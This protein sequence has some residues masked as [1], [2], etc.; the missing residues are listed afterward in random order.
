MPV[1][2]FQCRAAWFPHWQTAVKGT[3]PQRAQIYRCRGVAG[4]VQGGWLNCLQLCSL[5]FSLVFCWGNR[6]SFASAWLFLWHPSQVTNGTRWLL[7]AKWDREYQ[8][9]WSKP[10]LATLLKNYVLAKLIFLFFCCVLT[11]NLTFTLFCLTSFLVFW[12]T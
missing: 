6:A 11:G 1:S 4:R 5:F 9:N 3:H 7:A 2:V 10:L 12:S 8:K